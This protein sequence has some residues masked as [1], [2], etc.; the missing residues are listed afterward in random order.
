MKTPIFVLSLLLSLSLHAQTTD[1]DS[2]QTEDS[3]T[4]EDSAAANPPAEIDETVSSE[5]ATSST[6]TS[7][8]SSPKLKPLYFQADKNNLQVLPQRFEYTLLDQNRLKVGNILIDTTEIQ[9][10]IERTNDKKNPYAIRFQW[11]AGL[12]K[13]GQLAIKNNS[14]KA[15]FNRNIQSSD[16]KLSGATTNEDGLIVETAS[17]TFSDV[18]ASMID[19]MKYFPFMTFCIFKESYETRLYLCS[20]ELY[21]SSQGG[22]MVIKSRDSIKRNANIDINGKVVGNQGIIYLNDRN[23]NV[24]FKAHTQTGAFLEIET[25]MKDVDFK[26]VVLSPDGKRIILTASGAKPFD[27]RNVKIF[28]E[29]EWQITLPRSRP[30]LFLK[31]EGD[32]PMRQEFFIRGVLPREGNRIFVSP[33]SPSRTYSSSLRLTGVTPKGIEASTLPNE[34]TAALKKTKGQQFQWNIH[35]I[36][37]GVNSRHYLL[38]KHGD[39]AFTVGYDVFRGRPFVFDLKANYQTPSATGYASLGLQWWIENMLGLDADW[40]RFH[41][42]LSVR[43]ASQIMKNDEAPEFDK[44]NFELLWRAQEGFYFVD[45][46]WG[47]YL[48]V[49]MLQGSGSSLMAYGA[50]FFMHTKTQNPMWRKWATWSELKAQYLFAGT[51]DV[52]LSSAYQLGWTAYKNIS[53]NWYFSYGAFIED[54]KFDPAAPKEEMQIGAELGLRATF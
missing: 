5:E 45:S 38:S 43:Y 50:G 15:I 4:F 19:D 17:L 7:R 30:V 23:E 31:G 36:P 21:L 29:D 20:K 39:E 22:A 49:E 32:I 24:A 6:K 25:R 26:D 16:L 13:E 54:Y 52:E 3:I 35:D 1:V 53:S 2:S 42:G 37:S 14:G 40:A 9:F 28:S 51:G 46:T 41:W 34:T 18:D 44:I 8:K 33:R 10:Q 11:P 48:P 27:T 12:I 47:L